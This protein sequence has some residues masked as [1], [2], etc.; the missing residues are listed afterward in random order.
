ME[1][2][3]TNINNNNSNPKSNTYNNNNNNKHQIKLPSRNNKSNELKQKGEL[4][5]EKVLEMN[6][7]GNNEHSEHN[8]RRKLMYN[9]DFR[10]FVEEDTDEDESIL[11]EEEE[12]DESVGD[13]RTTRHR[14]YS[15]MAKY[16]KTHKKI[17]S[18]SYPSTR[19]NPIITDNSGNQNPEAIKSSNYYVDQYPFADCENSSDQEMYN[20]YN[21]YGKKI[22]HNNQDPLS[23][24]S[25]STPPTALSD[26]PNI[27]TMYDELS[28]NTQNLVLLSL[29]KR[30]PVSTLQFVSSLILPV[31]KFDIITLLPVELTYQILNYLDIEDIYHCMMVCHAWKKII[32]SPGAELAIWKQKLIEKQ[33]YDEE[34]IHAILTEYK[35]KRQLKKELKAKAKKASQ[36]DSEYLMEGIYT[37]NSSSSST[38]PYSSSSS[39]TS[40]SLNNNNNT[41]NAMNISNIPTNNTNNLGNGSSSS[42]LSSE[43]NHNTSINNPSMKIT[44]DIEGKYF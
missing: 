27:V 26:V 43:S 8:R 6:D 35:Q 39:S 30:C 29:L 38:T 23:P 24:Y 19:L 4:G 11:E 1:G 25:G 37:F 3:G 7:N 41:V 34:K 17:A 16:N 31:L 28:P 21:Q 2:E 22:N 36:P 13:E 32:D 10:S 9:N 15:L 18:S 5:D 12:E 20:E 14:H 40:T 44:N 33:W 42:Q